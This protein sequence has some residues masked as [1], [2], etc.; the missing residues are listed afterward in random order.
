MKQPRKAGR[1][2]DES[3]VR[4]ID[5]LSRRHLRAGWWALLGFLCM[6]VVLETL[7]GFKVG[8]Y[9]DVASSTRRHMWTL[10]HAHGTLLAV[11][12]LVFGATVQRLPQH[13]RS[14]LAS[15]CLLVATVL[16]PGGFLLGGLFPF[17]GDPGPGVLLVPVGAVF[18][19]LGVFLVA[20]SWSC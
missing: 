11:V 9:L 1:S 8:W 4:S 17:S 19:A 3:A 5:P 20:R 12:N 7:H 15:H 6:G 16:L 13:A 18:L 2:L 14:R 10:A